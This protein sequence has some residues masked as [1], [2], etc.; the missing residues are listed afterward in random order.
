MAPL[1]S[2]SLYW[3]GP[4]CSRSHQADHE[5]AV[6]LDLSRAPVDTGGDAEGVAHLIGGLGHDAELV[7]VVHAVAQDAQGLAGRL[8]AVTA[9]GGGAGIGRDRLV[10]VVGAAIQRVAVRDES[11]CAGAAGK[12]I[13]ANRVVERAG[14][15]TTTAGVVNTDVTLSWSLMVEYQFRLTWGLWKKFSRSLRKPPSW[16]VWVLPR[17]TAGRCRT[18]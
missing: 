17:N 5:F 10:P 4:R 8:G 12:T 18:G 6:V 2:N 7:L 15:T 14:A 1:A 11:E 13:D 16:R 3:P 9:D